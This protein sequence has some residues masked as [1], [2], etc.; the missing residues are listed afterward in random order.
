MT[1]T[2]L[3]VDRAST[4]FVVVEEKISGG[5]TTFD[6]VKEK[7]PKGEAAVA[8][9]GIKDEET[10]A[11]NGDIASHGKHVGMETE[12]DGEKHSTTC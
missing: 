4:K 12:S 9:N 7:F 10:A 2:R 11:K 3:P 5:T 8:G 6:L 1:N